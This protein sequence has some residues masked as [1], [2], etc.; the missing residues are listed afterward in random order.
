MNNVI[1][2]G[3]HGIF[4]F[5]A[6]LT[7]SFLFNPKLFLVLWLSFPLIVII[8]LIMDYI[9]K[10]YITREQTFNSRIV[11]HLADSIINFDIL[12][13]QAREDEKL[14]EFEDFIDL[15]TYFR[16]RRQL[17]IQYSNRVLY[18]V[19]LLFVVTLYF[20]QIY[21]PFIQFDSISNIASSGIIL[22]YFSSILFSFSRV[23]VF[24]EAFSL[25]L[26]L[27]TPNFSYS[28]KKNLKKEPKWSHLRF[29]GKKT[30]LSK[31]GGY[32]KNFKLNIAN[33]SRI[34]I[35]SDK[36]F[37]K[38][39]DGEIVR[40]LSGNVQAYQDTIQMFCDES[41]FFETQNRAEFY[42]NVIIDDSHHRL[43][44]NKIIYFSD[45]RVAHCEENVR[46]SGAND[47][48]YAEKFIYQFKSGDADAEENL[49][50]W[51][52]EGNVRIWGDKGRYN[53]ELRE[54]HINGNAVFHHNEIDQTDTLIITSQLMSYFGNDPKRALA[55]KNV[56]IFKGGVRAVCD[57]ATFFIADNLVTLRLNPI[58]WQGDNEMLGNDIDF[59]LDSLKIDEIFL[60]EN[61][62]IST[63]ADSIAKKYNVLRGKTIQISM[64]EGMP[65]RVIARRNAI[66][67]YLIE[68]NQVEQGTN[69]ASSDSIIVYFKEG[70]VDSIQIIGGT[71]GIFYPA[72]WKGEI[73]SEY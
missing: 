31:Y 19:L 70:L 58:A 21:W 14:K 46:I 34:L 61:A 38:L 64:S 56:E 10:Y 23:G 18:A 15:D 26:K 66:S 43:W 25:G 30:K 3:L 24:Y 6:I 16:I 62:K 4:L 57:S 52:K 39:I 53:G 11:S 41:I 35:Y 71:E 28:L 8:F 20:I 73:K 7:F 63:L 22:G 42:G 33:K 65:Q 72:D 50:L 13:A 40:Y 59:T 9:G 51:D 67:I 69:S 47:S 48:L 2:Q 54:S 44:A 49:F 68:E 17:W 55:R 12:K 32:I 37:G 1:Y 5:S 60:Y 27:C 45:T 29:S 36:S